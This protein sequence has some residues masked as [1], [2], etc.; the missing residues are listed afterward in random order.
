MQFSAMQCS[1]LG[2][3]PNAAQSIPGRTMQCRVQCSAVQRSAVQCRVIHSAT[4]NSTVEYK[5]P[6][7]ILNKAPDKMDRGA[8]Q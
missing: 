3:K 2:L 4:L 7:K 5:V 1:A 6:E 8:E